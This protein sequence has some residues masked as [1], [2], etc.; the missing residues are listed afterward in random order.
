MYIIKIIHIYPTYACNSFNLNT[1][2]SVC[3]LSVDL[4]IGVDH[5]IL[6]NNLNV[7]ALKLLND[8]FKKCSFQH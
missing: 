4:P 3:W 7:L 6:S 1:N 5:H 8:Q 2:F